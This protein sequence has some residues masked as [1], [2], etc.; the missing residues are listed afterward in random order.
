MMNKALKGS[1][2]AAA[3]IA[4]S[5]TGVGAAFAQDEAPEDTAPVASGTVDS[6]QDGVGLNGMLGEEEENVWA[7]LL[8]LHLSEEDTRLVYCIQISEPLQDGNVYEERPWEEIPVE[9]LPLVLGVLTS[10]YTGDNAGTLLEEAGV[11]GDNEDYDGYSWDQIAYAGT[12]AAIWHL[13]DGWE[14]N[15]DDPTV[16]EAAADGAVLAVQEYLLT[17]T[18]PV[19]EPD[20]TPEFEVDSTEATVDGT[21]AG[22][23]TIGTNLGPIGFTQPEGATIVDENGEEVTEFTDD[24]TVYVEFADEVSTTVSVLTDTVTW[25]TPM[26]RVF[27]PTST[28]AAEFVPQ[29]D[30]GAEDIDGQRVILAEEHSEEISAELEFSITVEEAPSSETP[31][32]TLPTTG[33]SL[34]AVAG[35]GGAVLVAGVVALVLMRRRA[36]TAGADWGD[37]TEEK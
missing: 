14:I 30:T 34:T 13:T 4:L 7:N 8:Q 3:G 15:A 2:A 24:Q 36:A 17:E 32:A 11:A 26:G 27:V 9:D 1:L 5:L 25:T 16:G 10:G 29:A 28:P 18:E 35:I 20:F 12:Q 37:D 21:T 19:D 23:F 22:P 6:S 31:Q 33:T